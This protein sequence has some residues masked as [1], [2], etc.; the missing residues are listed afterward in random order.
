MWISKK[1]YLRLSIEA[2]ALKESN[3][4]LLALLKNS[5]KTIR[6]QDKMFRKIQMKGRSYRGD[7][8]INPPPSENVKAPPT[9][10]PPPPK[11]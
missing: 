9:P 11:K 10:K 1:D 4:I 2:R 6:Q 7:V 8:N 5:A 3:E